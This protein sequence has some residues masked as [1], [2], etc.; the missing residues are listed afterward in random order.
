MVL[1]LNNIQWEMPFINFAICEHRKYTL[2]IVNLMY[3]HSIH[4]PSAT[5][6]L[7]CPQ[8]SEAADRG[9]DPSQRIPG[10]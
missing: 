1:A 5:A 7:F 9:Y 2:G 4:S 8:P 3:A 6:M 10:P